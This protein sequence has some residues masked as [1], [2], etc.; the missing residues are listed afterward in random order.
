VETLA[1][2]DDVSRARAQ[3]FFTARESG[4]LDVYG[5]EEGDHDEGDDA[6]VNMNEGGDNAEGGEQHHKKRSVAPI[7]AWHPVRLGF[8]FKQAGKL[9]A[10]L[11][12][13]KGIEGN[14][15]LNADEGV[16]MDTEAAAEED[17]ATL[18]TLGNE[19]GTAEKLDERLCYLIRVHG[20]D[21]YKR[22][23][24]MH[25]V[26]F[27]EKVTM[28]TTFSKRDPK[29]ADPVRP[30]AENPYGV[31][32]SAAID[33]NVKRRITEGDPQVKKLG[34]EEIERKLEEWVQSCVVKHDEQRYG[35]ALNCTKL[36]VAPE[37]LVKHVKTKHASAYEQQRESLIDEQFHRNVLEYL[38]YEENRKASKRGRRK[39][40]MF[41]G[42]MMMP[43][44]D[45]QFIQVPVAAQGG[46]R[47]IQGMARYTDLDASVPE[48]VVIDYGDI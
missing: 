42:M 41:G 11:D 24:E 14:P 26:T 34:T 2:R 48:R 7:E 28:T 45:G 27:L 15:L 22:V 23:S 25:P 44:A 9:I 19:E 5:A 30:V 1:R 20:I 8:D 33:G 4:S 47:M 10:A 43:G 35:C 29:P 3:E 39:G 37:F 36:F 21:Y 38:K 17:A 32:W 16:G 40:G 12:A 18:E 13:E 31:R 6:D 46:A